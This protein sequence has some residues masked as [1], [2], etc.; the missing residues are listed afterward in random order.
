MDD[1]EVSRLAA[2]GFLEELALRH[3]ETVPYAEL[4]VGFP[5][6]DRRI[7]L[8]GPQGIF[9][10]AGWSVPLSIATSPDN[11]Y[12]DEWGYAG[13]L[14]R[15]RGDD[16]RHRDNTGLRRAMASA[17]P[18]VYFHGIMRGE[19]MPVW[20]VYVAAADDARLTFTIVDAVGA[21]GRTGDGTVFE[22]PNRAY[23]HRL[24]KTRL[25]QVVFRRQVIAAYRERCAICSLRHLELLDAAH[26]LRDAHPRSLPE[27]PNGLSL[28]KLHHAA[29]DRNIVGVRPDL[30]VEVREDVLSEK[31]GPMLQHG[32]QG[33][34]GSRL[35]LPPR[36]AHHPN[37][38]FLAER[39][40]EFRQAG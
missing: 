34:E 32:L 1:G 40:E 23:A 30:V 25:H 35:L 7:K 13:L 31:D 26:I 39:Y 36:K 20:P 19:Y 27:V 9:T 2:F 28:C 17:T 21:E 8:L 4:K 5:F 12:G 29:F 14:Y 11:P 37:S 18:L 38:E 6:G 24:V 33:F 22:A 3:G 15:Y 10:P 16:P